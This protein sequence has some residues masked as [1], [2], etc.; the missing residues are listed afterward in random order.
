MVSIR[1]LNVASD[2]KQTFTSIRHISDSCSG[3]FLSF[4]NAKLGRKV[5]F[6][7]KNPDVFL[8]AILPSCYCTLAL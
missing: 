5:K 6:S 8:A 7:R 1:L 2:S 3:L 4:G